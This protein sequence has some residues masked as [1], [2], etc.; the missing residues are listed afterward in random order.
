MEQHKYLPIERSGL[1]RTG[2]K[3]N[4]AA[5]LGI[6]VTVMKELASDENYK[7]WYKKEKN[8]SRLIEEP[9]AA[10]DKVQKNLFAQLR[11]IQMP[12]WLKSGQR[13]IKPQDNALAHCG[14]VFL[15]N[16][17]IEAFFQSTKREFVYRCFQN[18]F[19]MTDDV[20][21]ILADLVTYKGHIPTG[22]S[23]SQI[24][25]FW[26]Y[27]KT[28]ERIQRLC[29]S[30][31]IEMTL[32]V[33]D[34]TF[35][36]PKPFPRGWTSDINKILGDVD[37]CLKTKKTKRYSNHE[38][39]TVTGSAVSP[40]GHLLVRNA[41]RKEILD[42]LAHRR[43]EDLTLKEARSLLG[44][45]ASQRQNEPDF[46]D[47]VYSRCKRH[48]RL[49]NAV[50]EANRPVARTRRNKRQRFYSGDEPPWL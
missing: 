18:E 27:K 40:E 45:L 49:L 28:F 24:M 42:I 4:L 36:S 30:K 16:V 3:R 41:K 9:R 37:L 7:E 34:I 23:T 35:S 13:G 5:L 8:K 17:D 14:N 38:F 43:V 32:W 21:S 22:T 39:K 31:R 48:I 29:E 19:R 44:K 50:N 11:K 33:D 15:V 6:S 20:A 46:F 12:P 1:Y 10:L 47:D 2:T 25:A 26:A